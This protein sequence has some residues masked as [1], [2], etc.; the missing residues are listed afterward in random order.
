MPGACCIYTWNL[1]ACSEE[2]WS[3][4]GWNGTHLVTWFFLFF[5]S[6]WRASAVLGAGRES[7]GNGA[8]A[9]EGKMGA[10]STCYLAGLRGREPVWSWENLYT[11]WSRKGSQSPCEDWMRKKSMITW[12]F[13]SNS[14]R[15]NMQTYLYINPKAA[16]KHTHLQV[17]LQTQPS[18][19]QRKLTYTHAATEKHNVHR[20]WRE[21]CRISRPMCLNHHHP[22]GVEKSNVYL[23]FSAN[24]Q[25][26]H[27]SLM[28]HSP[29]VLQSL[30]I[31]ILSHT[32][33]TQMENVA[34]R[35]TRLLWCGK[36][37]KIWRNEEIYIVAMQTT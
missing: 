37:G 25:R 23:K 17:Q 34:K 32:S 11:S 12:T 14:N 16:H 31:I 22:L 33:S 30:L 15:Y 26:P 27:L 4:R 2:G 1:L 24:F 13:S 18:A 35:L 21:S 5:C 8:G 10:G 28:N 20:D 29:R 7:Q 36:L 6:W 3:M 19:I 9:G